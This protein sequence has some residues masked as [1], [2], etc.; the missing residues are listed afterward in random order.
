[1][2]GLSLCVAPNAVASDKPAAK[3]SGLID[4]IEMPML[5]CYQCSE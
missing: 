2:L 4:G 5:L 1:M 3:L